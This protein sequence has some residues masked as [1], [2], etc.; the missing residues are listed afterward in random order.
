MI[1]GRCLTRTS[2]ALLVAVSVISGCGSRQ[3]DSASSSKLMGPPPQDESINDAAQRIESAIESGD[4]NRINA[5]NPL[6]RPGI[7]TEK[8]CRSLTH[9]AGFK[10]RSAV[11]YGKLGGVIVYDVELAD[12]RNSRTR[13]QTVSSISRSRSVHRHARDHGAAASSKSS[14]KRV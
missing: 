5:L 8:R 14:R 2:V 9:L 13:T 3:G 11:Q 10:V 7:S 1:R 4:C 12:R 6:G